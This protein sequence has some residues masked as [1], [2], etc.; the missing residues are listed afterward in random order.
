MTTDV[1][2]LQNAYQQIIRTSVRAPFNLLSSIVMCFVISPQ[3]SLI[4]II[5]SVVLGIILALII[6]KVSKTV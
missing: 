4:F 2:N 3:L 6:S 1:T 5:A